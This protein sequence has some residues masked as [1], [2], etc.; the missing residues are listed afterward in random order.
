LRSDRHNMTEQVVASRMALAT[1]KIKLKGATKGHSLLKKKSDALTVRL[2]AIRSKLHEEKLSMGPKMKESAFTLAEVFWAAGEDI[3]YTILENQTAATTKVAMQVD[4]VAGVHLPVFSQRNLA[5]EGTNDMTGL[6]KGGQQLQKSRDA[7]IKAI[8]LL[9]SP[10]SLQT[11]FITL[12]Y[13]LKVTNRRVNALEYVVKP[14]IERTIAYIISELD[15]LEREEFFRL[16]KIQKKKEE[17]I[18]AEK[19]KLEAKAAEMGLGT[20]GLDGNKTMLD[21]YEAD[22]D[23]VV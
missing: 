4:N 17:R 2:R 9:I 1:W 5:V 6:G 19:A 11:Q 23:I 16:K 18:K 8:E 13:A 22:P 10:A 15:E 3:K 12:D 21:A 20:K 14:R 7:H